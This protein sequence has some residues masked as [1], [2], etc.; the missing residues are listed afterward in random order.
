[1]DANQVQKLKIEAETDPKSLIIIESA[2]EWVKEHTTLDFDINNDD[3]LEALPSCVRLFVIRFLELNQ[4]SAGVTSESIEGLSQAFDTS[5]KADLI[6]DYA[7][8]LLS[9]YLISPI[10]FV[11]AQRKWNYGYKGKIHDQKG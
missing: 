3:D 7:N 5:K 1:M 6:W 4:L 8:E 9:A 10:K 11:T 2:L